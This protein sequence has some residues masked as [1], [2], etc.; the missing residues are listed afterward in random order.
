VGKIK[1]L[2][3][4]KHIA[5][6]IIYLYN[7]KDTLPIF[8]TEDLE[9]FVEKLKLDK[10]RE[11]LK[12]FN[13]PYNDLSRGQKYEILNNLLLNFKSQIQEFK[14]WDNLTFS[15]FLYTIIKPPR[16]SA[17]SVKGRSSQPL[18]EIGLLYEP[19]NEME[20]IVLFAMYHRELGFPYILRVGTEF[21]DAIV[22]DE[23]GEVK[24]IEFELF[25]KTFQQHNHPIN[26][27]DYIICWE[28]NWKDPPEEAASKII[29]LK[30]KLRDIIKS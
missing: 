27:C 12:I 14:N 11:A 7:S 3:G 1:G 6:K 9:Y 13:K 17:S 16:L 8:K 5:K 24:R 26:E 4:D 10:D 22:L 18:S 19:Q 29:V 23:N 25:S 20:V 21:P 2:G 30:E 15:K 28:D